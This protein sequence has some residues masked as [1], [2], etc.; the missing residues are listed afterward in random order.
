MNEPLVSVIVPIFNTKPFLESCVCSI[1]EQTYGNLEIILVDDGS[2]DGSESLCDELAAKDPRIVVAHLENGGV[3]SARNR[4]LDIAQG[5]WMAFVDSDDVVKPWYVETLLAAAL[6]EDAEVVLGGYR[7]FGNGGG[8]RHFAPTVN[9][10]AVSARCALEMLMYQEGIDTAPWG[11]LFRA[12]KFEGVR[13]PSLPSSEDLATIYKPLLLSSRV[14]IVPD[15]GYC[16]RLT[17]GSLSSSNRE[18]AAWYVARSASAD[19][20]KVHPDL[21]DACKCRRLSFAFHVLAQAKDQKVIDE[22]W[23]EVVATR[24]T[25][26]RDRRARKKARAAA[27]L[28]YAGKIFVLAFFKR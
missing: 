11:K 20:L 18:E 6:G 23:N 9:Q 14:A 28:S 10:S 26:L 12:D 3:G 8:E 17:E 21:M 16:Y 5:G 27:L 13:F 7:S 1:A 22:L 4:A 15:S 24:S 19:I 25:V 2:T